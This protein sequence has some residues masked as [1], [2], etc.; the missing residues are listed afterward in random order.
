MNG[1]DRSRLSATINTKQEDRKDESQQEE[2]GWGAL[3]KAVATG[4]AVIASA[5]VTVAAISS[6]MRD[7][8][9][10]EVGTA[11]I[12][13]SRYPRGSSERRALN[14]TVHKYDDSE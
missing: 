6:A 7:A 10:H 1:G 3:F 4:V 13:R 12:E 14:N 2:S 9:A 11:A 5:A 8:Q